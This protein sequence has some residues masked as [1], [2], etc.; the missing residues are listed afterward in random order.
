MPGAPARTDFYCLSPL[1]LPIFLITFP[2][3]I[4]LAFINN[5]TAEVLGWF[6][7]LTITSN[8]ILVYLFGYSVSALRGVIKARARRK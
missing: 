4:L 8:I 1:G 7:W 3:S 2:S 5:G 6:W